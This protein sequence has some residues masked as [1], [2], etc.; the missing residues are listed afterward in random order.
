VTDEVPVIEEETIDTTEISSEPLQEIPLVQA[1]EV[2]VEGVISEQADM[3]SPTAEV[4]A[5]RVV[6][7]ENEP[8]AHDGEIVIPSAEIPEMPKPQF[9]AGVGTEPQLPADDYRIVSKTLA[10]IYASQGEYG[11]ALMTYRLLKLQR[12][13]LGEVIDKRIDELE[14]LIHINPQTPPEK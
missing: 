1:D 14:K 2:P 13:E 4:D 6:H 5:E 12:P 3:V 9:D 11:E 7:D 10:E 8:A